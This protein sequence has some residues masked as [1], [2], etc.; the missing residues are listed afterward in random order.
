LA[1]AAASVWR[2]SSAATVQNLRFEDT[3][4]SS[5]NIGGIIYWE[6]EVSASSYVEGTSVRAS[7]YNV[8]LS[9]DSSGT[10]KVL[11]GVVDGGAWTSFLSVPG[12]TDISTSS[13]EYILVYL[14]D[15]SATESDVAFIR[16]LDDPN[17]RTY[18]ATV[19][20]ITAAKNAKAALVTNDD[21]QGPLTTIRE[22]A[23]VVYNGGT[24]DTTDFDFTYHY[25][26]STSVFLLTFPSDRTITTI[27][28]S[29]NTFTTSAPFEIVHTGNSHGDTSY[30]LATL[31][32]SSLLG[33]LM[34]WRAD[35]DVGK[36]LAKSAV[37]NGIA[38]SATIDRDGYVRIQSKSAQD[39]T[40]QALT[41]VFM[42]Y[43]TVSFSSE[44]GTTTANFAN[45]DAACTET[46]AR[47]Y[48]V[49]ND[50]SHI[51]CVPLGELR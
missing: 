16:I 17:T 38:Y 48:Q 51:E 10:T 25:Y 46:T 37:T 47:C 1:I 9:T 19:V 12:G 39:T 36:S 45:I 32:A 22:V 13:Y 26:S 23:T 20:G 40:M 14:E 33:G 2:L 7:H 34:S 6:T 41:D 44:L 49:S 24:V 35:I 50:L 43:E 31:Q 29:L 4:T 3:D 21:T 11:L 30:R 8:Y 15:S 18:Y 28:T 42:G 27:G 5:G